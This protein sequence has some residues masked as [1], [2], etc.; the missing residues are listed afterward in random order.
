MSRKILIMVPG[1][2]RGLRSAGRRAGDSATRLADLLGTPKCDR[3][4]K[5]EIV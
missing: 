3:L 1:A 2:G 4:K 5:P